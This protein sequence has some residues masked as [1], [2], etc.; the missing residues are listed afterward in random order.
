MWNNNGH[1]SCGVYFYFIIYVWFL[2]IFAYITSL[3]V[4]DF[5]HLFRPHVNRFCLVVNQSVCDLHVPYFCIS[6]AKNKY[7]GNCPIFIPNTRWECHSIQW[8]HWKVVS[9]LLMN[10]CLVLKRWRLYFSPIKNY[11]RNCKCLVMAI[12]S[13]FCSYL[14]P[15]KVC[16][17]YHFN[18]FWF[19]FRPLQIGHLRPIHTRRYRTQKLRLWNEFLGNPEQRLNKNNQECIPTHQPHSPPPM[20]TPRPGCRAP[21]VIWPVMHA[22]KPSPNPRPPPPNPPPWT[23]GMTHACENITFPQL[24]LQA[25]KIA[26]AFAFAWYE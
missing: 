6:T 15:K 8:F 16:A 10:S 7:R 13:G 19:P 21:L 20:L 3:C 17:I 5:P 2:E 4:N 1:I 24:L 14:V 22:G 11:V 9:W 25:V 18:E 12:I 26:F 23:E